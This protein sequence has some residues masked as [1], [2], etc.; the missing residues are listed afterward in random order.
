MEF[1]RHIGKGVWAFADKLLPVIWGICNIFLVQRVLPISEY[2]GLAVTLQIFL[3]VTMLNTSLAFQPLIKFVAEGEDSGKYISASLV[4]SSLFFIMSGGVLVIFKSFFL[5]LLDRTG[6]GNLGQL[7]NFLPLMF[8]MAWFRNFAV[9][10][11]QA[12]YRVQ[13]IFWIDSA[14][15]IG[16]PLLILLAQYFGRYS[17][18]RDV[19]LINISGLAA[20]TLVAIPLTYNDMRFG[21]KFDKAP[22]IQM[23]NFGK[24]TFWGSAMYTFFGQADV[25]FVSS[26]AG[27]LAVAPYSIAKTFTRVFD[28]MT[29]VIQMFLVPFSSKASTQK[30]R[31]QLSAV[32]EKT[33]CFS[34]LL[35]L[36]IF[37][38]LFF[39]PQPMLHLLY[40]G[41]FDN[42]APLLR[43]LSLLSFIAPWNAV[44]GSYF[45]GTGRVK[46]GFI[47]GIFLMG[48]SL[49]LYVILTPL[50]GAKGT[51]AGL[52]SAFFIVT[53]G[54]VRYQQ[55]IAPLRLGAVIKRVS[56]INGFMQT[57]VSNNKK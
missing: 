35:F 53:V 18:A 31:T 52:V 47:S 36:P 12:K 30:N 56:D 23:Y 50:F 29:Q 49:I 43:I 28:M 11:L 34:T 57:M 16:V 44:V 3:V 54:L 1:G 33:V 22:F 26:Y 39:F 24:F 17:V 51:A 41:K 32:A 19:I 10:L 46:E 25:F 48:I 21:I 14:Y 9:S 20:S 4:I 42:A 5:H 6:Q 45:V 37:I 2:A 13:R 55:R 38:I 27:I 40:R 8:F 15:Y 7:F